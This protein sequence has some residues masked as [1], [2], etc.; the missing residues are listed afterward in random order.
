MPLRTRTIALP[1][2]FQVNYGSSGRPTPAYRSRMGNYQIHAYDRSSSTY[3]TSTPSFRR[4]ITP[5]YSAAPVFDRLGYDGRCDLV[6]P[7]QDF[8]AHY[9]VAEPRA[10]SAK[11][12]DLQVKFRCNPSLSPSHSLFSLYSDPPGSSENSLCHVG[13]RTSSL[14]DT[15]LSYACDYTTRNMMAAQASIP[16]VHVNDA[17]EHTVLHETPMSM[18]IPES[19]YHL[20]SMT[21]L[22]SRRFIRSI[23][24]ILLRL[25]LLFRKGK[26]SIVTPWRR[27]RL[28]L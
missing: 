16:P 13:P 6:M 5:S 25:P 23:S 10:H 24:R 18:S 21:S 7:R 17:E 12:G 3:A 19:W 14:D 9:S 20:F 1:N 4:Q 8:D 27:P 22:Q 2:P 15:E 11:T 28:F 26:I